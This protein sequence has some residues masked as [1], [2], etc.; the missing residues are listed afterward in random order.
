M[1][2]KPHLNLVEI[3]MENVKQIFDYHSGLVATH[4]YESKWYTWPFVVRPVWFCGGADLPEGYKETIAS[5]GNP[6]VWIISFIAVFISLYFT[7]KDKDRNGVI[8]LLAYAFQYF[9][10]ILVTR[11]AFIYSYLTALPFSVLLLAYCVS[12]I[13][14]KNKMLEILI[15]LYMF[16]VAEWF[17][18]FYPVLTGIVVKTSYVEW[19]RW[20]PTWYF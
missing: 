14:H 13:K 9:P 2:S 3:A 16:I 10:W 18:L 19:L 4:D 6:A 8:L 15:G 12:K 1:P 17:I 11:I 7:W 20:L 5:F